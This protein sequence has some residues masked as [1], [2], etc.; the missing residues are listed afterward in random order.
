MQK[1]GLGY[2]VKLALFSGVLVVASAGAALAV[3]QSD[4]FEAS[5]TEFGSGA[6]LESCSGEY[7][8]EAT[9][10]NI[11]A[12]GNGIEGPA[13][14]AS[15]GPYAE[16]GEPMT[17]VIIEEG[18]SNLGVL[19]T[20]STASKTVIIK[21]RSYRTD[22]YTLQ[23]IGDPPKFAGHTLATPE[24]P[25]ASVP[26]EE[27]FGINA[28]ANT[29][30]VVGADPKQVP[31][32]EFSFG[33]VEADYAAANLFKYESGSVVARSTK[34]SGQTEYTLS[35]IVNVAGSTPAGHYVSDFS[36]VVIPAF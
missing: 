8:A 24:T 6:A 34:E 5:E 33:Q 4:N 23:I 21:I 9:I 1:I 3:S 11:A 19:K 29:S 32:P 27:Q 13:S 22:G 2:V 17:E 28:V 12:A 36:A 16:D 30:P 35:M 15:F 26:G 18:I 31:N 7:C 14:K 25:A 10:G 20:D